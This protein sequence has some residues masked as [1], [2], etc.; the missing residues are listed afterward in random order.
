MFPRRFSILAANTPPDRPACFG[1]VWSNSHEQETLSNSFHWCL[2]G[3]DSWISYSPIQ[4]SRYQMVN[5]RNDA[6]NARSDETPL[7]SNDRENQSDYWRST[8]QSRSERSVPLMIITV[9]RCIIAVLG[10]QYLFLVGGFAEC[11]LLQHD[12][13]RAFSS[14]LKVIIPQDVSLTILKGSSSPHWRV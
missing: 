13:R 7:L 6:I 10:V 12:I 9:T 1:L 14:I 2:L 11:P 8:K 4:R 5:A 3:F